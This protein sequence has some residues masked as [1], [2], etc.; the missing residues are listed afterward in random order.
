MGFGFVRDGSETKRIRYTGSLPVNGRQVRAAIVFDDLELAR[1][2]RLQL[3]APGED[4][5]EL[6]AHVQND[7]DYCY[8]HRD[9]HV[10]DRFE[11]AGSV[12]FS[13]DLM[14][15]SLERSQ[16]SHA[17][18]EIAA[19]FPQHWFGHS[20]YI[21]LKEPTGADAK[22]F[23]LARE[24]GDE[25]DLL[26]DSQRVL[27]LLAGKRKLTEHPVAIVRPSKTLS[28]GRGQRR[29]ET[30]AEFM[31]WLAAI[32]SKAASEAL[33]G[34]KATY[35]HQPHVFLVAP[36]GTVGV[37]LDFVPAFWN[38]FKR[39]AALAWFV[40][41]RASEV[42]IT[43]LI[44]EAVGPNFIY[45]RNMDQDPNLSNNRIT[46]VGCGT[47][48]SHLA[49][50]LAQAGGGYGANGALGLIDQQKLRPGNI[51]R[52]LLGL[53]DIGRNKAT[54]V[55]DLLKRFYPDLSVSA[56]PE[57]VLSRLRVLDH[58]DL[59]IDATGDEGV[60]NA[61][62]AHFVDRWARGEPTPTVIFAWLMGNG[63][64]AQAFCMTSP[65]DACYRCLRP[66]HGGPWRFSPLK[67]D[68]QWREV[69]AQCGEAPFFPYGVAAPVTAAALGLQMALDWTNG[70]PSPRLRTQRLILQGMVSGISWLESLTAPLFRIL[71]LHHDAQPRTGRRQTLPVRQGDTRIAWCRPSTRQ[72]RSK[73]QAS[74]RLVAFCARPVHI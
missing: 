25:I 22:L 54:A 66:D 5:P 29:P 59:V 52:H 48:G 11:V 12:A 51:G 60:A 16:T 65:E 24:A 42:K 43:R 19:E 20:V 38:S 45:T 13:I 63:A 46:V 41:H 33:E 68:Y 35:P 8:A 56:A 28:F 4:T 32:D 40:E 18:N 37:R 6:L 17:A 50:M 53:P 71:G 73:V 49:K 61:I 34:V 15:A 27:G 62:N 1:L 70:N 57:D 23:K 72:R 7:G 9:G 10:I 36:N 64:A 69:T 31:A 47:I 2:P 14:R 74:Y 30:F 3:L 21:D 55:R 67:S 26:T 44:G 39:A 58:S